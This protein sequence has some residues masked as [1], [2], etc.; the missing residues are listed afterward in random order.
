[1]RSS[2][3]LFVRVV[4]LIL[5]IFFRRVEVVGVKRLPLGH[6]MVLVANHVNSLID[7]LFLLGSLPVRPRTL[8]DLREDRFLKHDLNLFNFVINL[9]RELRAQGRETQP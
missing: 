2:P 9:N 4:R 6:P 7:P 3:D 8:A 5:R 1:M